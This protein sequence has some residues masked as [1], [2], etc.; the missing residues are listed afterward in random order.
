[1]EKVNDP[2]A[3]P[4]FGEP[5]AAAPPVLAYADDLTQRGVTCR[6]TPDGIH[7]IIPDAGLSRMIRAPRWTWPAFVVLEVVVN[8]PILGLAMLVNGHVWI[9]LFRFRPAVEVKVSEREIVILDRRDPGLLPRTHRWRRRAV[10]EFRPNQF[11]LALWVR[12]PGAMFDDV[13]RGLERPLLEYIALHVQPLLRSA[14]ELEN[15][16]GVIE[17]SRPF[18]PDTE[19]DKF[20]HS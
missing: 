11:D 19:R 14:G 2:I 20:V 5:T 1:V 4:T 15:D 18:P 6:T 7:L 17:S 3:S 10:W 12:V 16:A 8:L 9:R 13:L